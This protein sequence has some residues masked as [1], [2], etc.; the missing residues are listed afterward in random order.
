MCRYS[1]GISFRRMRGVDSV[2]GW[3]A[4]T[5]LLLLLLEAGEGSGFRVIGAAALA[6]YADA[7]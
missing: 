7:A 1:G 5:L 4:L 6:G 3:V 2:F